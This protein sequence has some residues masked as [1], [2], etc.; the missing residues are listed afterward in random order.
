MAQTKVMGDQLPPV[1]LGSSHDGAVVALAVGVSFSC[2]L[3]G[4]GLAHFSS[5]LPQ[6]EA[7]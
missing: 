6:P 1:D 4:A 2:A 5:R 3:N 7:H